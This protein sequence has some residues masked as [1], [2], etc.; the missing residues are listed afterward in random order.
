MWRVPSLG[1]V[2]DWGKGGGGVVPLLELRR[3]DEGLNDHLLPLV[4]RSTKQHLF[5]EAC[6]QSA[7]MDSPQSR[8]CHIKLLFHCSFDIYFLNVGRR[9]K[10]KNE[11]TDSC[12]ENIH[13]V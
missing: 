7:L 2:G 5:P 9:V 13:R 12:L 4:S 10:V 3:C 8:S 11:V 6:L 1:A